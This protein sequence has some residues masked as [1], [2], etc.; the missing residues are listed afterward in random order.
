M[1]Q[2]H[3]QTGERPMRSLAKL[4]ATMFVFACAGTHAQ[5]RAALSIVKDVELQP[6]VAQ[7]KRVAEALDYLGVPLR[8]GRSHGPRSGDEG[9][10]RGDGDGGHSEGARSVL[11]RGRRADVRQGN[12]RRGRTGQAQKLVEQGWTQFLVK[13]HNPHGLDGRAAGRQSQCPAAG[14]LAGRTTCP[15]AGSTCRCSTSSRSC[16]S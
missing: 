10:G 4:V 1:S 2:P 14:R 15:A 7:V 9:N 6:L 13:V 3:L 8:R 11:P 12:H 5:D 16:P